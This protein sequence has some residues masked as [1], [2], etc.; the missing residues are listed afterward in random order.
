MK[1]N[2]KLVIIML[3]LLVIAMLTLFVM[4]QFSQNDLVREI[5][6]SSTEVTKAIQISVEDLTSEADVEA[7][8]LKE[9]L[10]EARNKGIYEINIINDEGEIIDSSDPD[11][12][13]KTRE[14]KKLEKGLKA[15]R[16]KGAPGVSG[17]SL[18]PYDLVVPVIVGDE[19]LGYVQIN[20]LLDNIRDIQHANFVRR[21]IATSTIFMVGIIL[22]IFLAR[23]YTDPIHRLS[24]GVKKVATGDLSVTFPVESSDEIGELARNFND[25]VE[26]LREREHLEKRLYEAEHLS[27]VGQLASGIAHEIRNPLNYISLAIDHLKS[28][29]IP[30]CGARQEEMSVVTDKIKEEVRRANYMVVNF[31]NYGRPLKVR[32]T[33]TSYAELIAK[34]LPVL[35]DRLDEQHIAVVLDIPADL[36]AMMVDPEL[37][38]NC[39][40]NFIT[41]ASQAMPNGG[42]IV[43]GAAC[44]REAAV[45][46]LT[47]TD[48]GVGIAEED[49]G[50][51]F[52]PYFTTREAG[53]GLGLAITERIIREHGGEILVVSTVGVGTTFTIVLPILGKE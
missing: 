20:M 38:R 42:T 3:S 5:Q 11:K 1:L 40:F 24:L 30:I 25:M 29:F 48:Q 53:I 27:K 33:A 8:R 50:K 2:A 12:V 7:S 36:P 15:A 21:L 31:M 46:R 45:F 44:D 43:L 9:Y 39:L 17:S 34:A 16:G 52:Q 28:E 18:R 32:R 37:L 47:F 19:L 26:K 13:G 14:I 22:T 41:N 6:E 4:N 23:R 51:I 10:K 35:R 49:L